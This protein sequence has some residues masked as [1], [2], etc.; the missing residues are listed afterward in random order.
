MKSWCG[1]FP[2]RLA[3][4]TCEFR[5]H[6]RDSRLTSGGVWR[7]HTSRKINM[8]AN[9]RG[10][11]FLSL[12][13]IA[14]GPMTVWAQ[15]NPKDEAALDFFERKV[16]P[17][18]VNNCYNCHSAN[19]NSKGG[20]RVDDRNG[21]LVGGGRG[22][23]VVP[24]Q[25]EKSLLMQAVRHTHAKLKM[26][27]EKHLADEEIGDL[28]KWIRDGAA[29][30]QPRV[31]ASIGRPNA[32]YEKLRKEHWAWQPLHGTKAPAVKQ[33]AWVRDDVDRYLLA[34]LE[35]KGLAPVKDADA[36]TLIRRVTFDLTGLPPTPAEAEEFVAAL[37]GAGAKRGAAYEKVVD[38]LLA[39]PAFGE[40][41]GRHWL[42]VARYGESTGSA[43]NLPYPHAWRYRDYVIEAFNTDKP[44]DQFI[45]EQ[46]AG[47]LLPAKS[48]EERD[49]LLVA[50]G[51]LAI[52]VRD[53]NQRFKVRFVMDNIDEQIDTV[54]RSVLALT[55]SCAR[56]HDHKFDPIPQIDY[57]SLAGIF[58]SCKLANVPLGDKE[59]VKRREET[60][61]KIKKF[62]GE[63]KEFLKV[64]KSQRA[65]A[66]ADELSRYLVAAWKYQAAKQKDMKASVDAIAKAEMLDQ[67]VLNRCVKF[68][69]K[70]PM[71]KKPNV[72]DADM[73]NAAETTQ[74]QVKTMIADKGKLD[75]TK[76]DLLNNLFYADDSVFQLSDAKVR[77]QLP[78]EKKKKLDDM[79]ATLTK[80]QKS[81]DAKPL[82]IAHGLAETTPANMKVF[83]RGNPA[84][85]L[86]EAPRRFLKIL[87]DNPKPFTQGSGRLELAE[88]IA[89]KDNPLTARVMVNRVWQYHFGRPIVG[90]PSNFGHLG[91]RPTHPELLDYLAVKF[92]SSPGMSEA[93]PG[94]FAWSLKKLHREIML[95]AV[96]QLSS[97][98]ND[99]NFS[100]DGDNRWLWRMNRRRLDIESWRD[101]ML[102]V[103]GKLDAKLGGPTTNLAA[104]DNNRRTVYAKISRHDLN[105]LLRLFDFPDANITSERRTETTVPQQQLFVM[106][107]PFVIEVSKALAARVQKEAATDPERVQRAFALAYGRPA[108]AEEAQVF[109]AFL[110]GKDAEPAANRL[111]RWERVAQIL[112]GSNEFMYVD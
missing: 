60:Q 67:A 104:V 50:T 91:D 8:D 58:T 34:G 54:T 102:A 37:D 96:Y 83:Y 43:R 70:T 101:A 81:D 100:S 48:N 87:T 11:V 15:P 89:S 78:E 20:L 9:S 26:P 94:G 38:R 69:E 77:A 4:L 85:P 90:T 74:K 61:A 40:R 31:P 2:A 55:A 72:P 45:C 75:K 79:T 46:I 82:P 86:E 19:T 98:Q 33:S 49:R 7:A 24:G 28:A 21:L 106:N 23:A 36:L 68:V 103:S 14:L 57:Y 51:F 17:V 5:G 22:P 93:I 13:L 56:C 62:D 27:P 29:W 12:A 84:K 73:V 108:A 16:R 97:E 107:S 3:E 25:P 63:V 109:V 47:D 30:P 35:A 99:K 39:S 88:A 105:P 42:D 32:K 71:M 92:S 112:I 66:K 18:L 64:E 65:S 95:S 111:T 53:V 44:Y 76:T 59:S 6:P 10:I 1:D 80:L 110:Q 41:W 52:G